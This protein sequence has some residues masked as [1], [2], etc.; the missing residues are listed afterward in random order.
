MVNVFSICWKTE[1]LR[2]CGL[3]IPLMTSLRWQRNVLIHNQCCT[4][5][6]RSTTSRQMSFVTDEGGVSFPSHPHSQT[7]QQCDTC[8]IERSSPL[9]PT[10]GSPSIPMPSRLPGEVATL[11]RAHG[12]FCG[13]ASVHALPPPH[14]PVPLT[15]AGV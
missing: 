3:F 4:F 10:D 13:P 6:V 5:Q 11:T 9:T 15:E 14:S 12:F 8:T 2:V 1:G 7:L